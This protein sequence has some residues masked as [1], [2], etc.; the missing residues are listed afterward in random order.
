M[1]PGDFDSHPGLPEL[2][3]TLKNIEIVDVF[4][5]LPKID[6]SMKTLISPK[7]IENKFS[8]TFHLDR[9]I[10]FKQLCKQ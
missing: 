2:A 1:F 4:E 9:S 7:L 3:K 10:R 8:G 5:Q 6:H